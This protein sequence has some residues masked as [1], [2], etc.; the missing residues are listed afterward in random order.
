VSRFRGPLADSYAAA[1]AL[2]VFALVPYL[3]LTAALGPLTPV[4][5]KSLDLSAQALQLTDG[6]A[7]AAYAIGTVLAVQF[8]SHLP[9]RRMLLLYSTLFVIAS[10]LTALAFTPG[11]YIAGHI[12]QG[13]LT[14]LMLIAAVPPLVIGWPTKRMPWTGGIMNMCIFGAVAAGPAVGG[15]QAASGTWRTLFWL[16]AAS[17]LVAWVFVLATYEDQE[18]QDLTAPWDRTALL[19]AAGGCSCAFFGVSELET[20]PFMSLLVFLPLIVGLAAIAGLVVHQ[21]GAR[22]PLMPV[23]IMASTKPVA[24]IIVALCAGAASFAAIEL[25]ELVLQKTTTPGHAAMLW[26]PQLGGAVVSAFLFGVLFR[27]RAMPLLPLLGMALI[28]AGVAVVTGVS[29]GPEVL[30]IV[31]SGLLG[32][33]VGASVSPALFVAGFSAP[34]G[35]IQRVFALIELLRAVAAF[36]AAPVIVHIAMT[37]DGGPDGSGIETGLWI[38]LGIAAAGGLGAMYVWVLGRARLEKPDLERW[39]AGEEPAWHSP[40]LLAGIRP[41]R[42]IEDLPIWPGAAMRR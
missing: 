15:V 19:L 39:E 34:S 5:G 26:W 32:L 20:H 27:R 29:R 33:G 2:V 10:V 4:I 25:V 21:F 16:V 30:V 42:H 36:M 40:R 24:G 8:A 13:L 35:Q 18:P 6:M 22:R 41:R 9:A 11:L 31:G 37:T 12:L 38:C 7:N 14:S 28:G 17:G 1:A 23:R 3:V